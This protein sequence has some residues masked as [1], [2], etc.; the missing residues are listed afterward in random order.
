MPENGGRRFLQMYFH[1]VKVR[2]QEHSSL[3]VEGVDHVL[4]WIRAYAPKRE[5]V[6]L[7][8]SYRGERLSRD[9]VERMVARTAKRAEIAKRVTPHTFRHSRATHLLRL[10]VTEPQVRALLGWAS[11][12]P[13]IGRYSHLVDRDGYAALL[14]AHG[15]E[16]PEES[17]PGSLVPA[18]GELR[19]V[20]PL[21][22]PPGAKPT[23]D[24]EIARARAARQAYEKAIADLE[25]KT[26]R[27]EARYTEMM[28][29]EGVAAI[30]ADPAAVRVIQA[31]MD[32]ARPGAASK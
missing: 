6:P 12:S 18:E 27:L 23:L 31:A 4:A 8:P 15:L 19:P 17:K 10:G 26:Q 28:S 2:G 20:L 5:D 9:A 7:F 21:I 16:P 32:W 24:D 30:M 29:D 14:R 11:G 3:L 13:L 25:T 1:T 22:A